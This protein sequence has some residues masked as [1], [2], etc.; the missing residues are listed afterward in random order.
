MLFFPQR[1]QILAPF[2]PE[3]FYEQVYFLAV[4]NVSYYPRDSVGP[5]FFIGAQI[6][7]K[8]CTGKIHTWHLTRDHFFFAN[9]IKKPFKYDPPCFLHLDAE[10]FYILFSHHLGLMDEYWTPIWILFLQIF[11]ALQ[12]WWLN[13]QKW[14]FVGKKVIDRRFIIFQAF[15][16]L[17]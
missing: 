10:T 15:V 11:M 6:W 17:H 4:I 5:K 1:F 12:N 13:R 8:F 2:F 14:F 16:L 9:N 7:R 3:F